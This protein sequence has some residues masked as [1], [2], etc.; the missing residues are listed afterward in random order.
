MVLGAVCFEAASYSQNK[1]EFPKLYAQSRCPTNY[2]IDLCIRVG[3]GAG[4]EQDIRVYFAESEWI[5]IQFLKKKRS[6][7]ETFWNVETMF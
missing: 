3:H 7:I 4:A 6:R 1:Q 2:N 5:H